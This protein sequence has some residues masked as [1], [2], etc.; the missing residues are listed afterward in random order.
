MSVSRLRFFKRCAEFL[1]RKEVTHIPR[2]TRGVYVLLKNEIKA[3]KNYQVMYVGMAGGNRTG[4]HGRLNSPKKSGTKQKKWTHFSIFEVWDNITEPEIRELE[5]LLRHI[6]RKDREALP[7]NVSKRFMRLS[8]VR[9][10]RMKEW[11]KRVKA[12]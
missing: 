9:D 8:K 11:A 2:N 10:N 5:G 4:I 7:L 3:K 1:P 6:F 12:S